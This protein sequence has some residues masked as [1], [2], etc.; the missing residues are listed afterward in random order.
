MVQDFQSQN[1]CDSPL[2]T[3]TL[4]PLHGASALNLE[5]ASIASER[6]EVKDMIDSTIDGNINVDDCKNELS[7]LRISMDWAHTQMIQRIVPL[8]FADIEN[9]ILKQGA[10]GQGKVPVI[11]SKIDAWKPIYTKFLFSDATYNE[12]FKCVY[13]YCAET[14]SSIIAVWLQIFWKAQII[15]K[16]GILNWYKGLQGLG[17]EYGD[18]CVKLLAKFVEHLEDEETPDVYE[19]SE[20]SDGS[21]EECS[22]S[23]DEEESD[24]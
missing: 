20:S 7:N 14:E 9:E 2:D 6:D 19:E 24:D 23:E 16:T 5:N 13:E 1:C 12:F 3:S 17:S 22:D 18:R 15:K 10:T 21:D 4:F 11:I 8:I